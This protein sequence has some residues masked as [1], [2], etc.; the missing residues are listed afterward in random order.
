MSRKSMTARMLIALTG[1]GAMSAA[2]WAQ[3]GTLEYHGD[4]VYAQAL[5]RGRDMS[6]FVGTI[7]VDGHTHDLYECDGV[8]AGIIEAIE[9]AGYDVWLEGREIIVDTCHGSPRIRFHSH[10][11]RLSTHRSHDELHLTLRPRHPHH[12]DEVEVIEPPIVRDR[13][14]VEAP[15]IIFD[16][17]IGGGGRDRGGYGGEYRGERERNERPGH[18]DERRERDQRPGD[19]DD[20]G[21][22]GDRGERYEFEDDRFEDGRF[23]ERGPREFGGREEVRP[24]SYETQ[25]F[26]TRG[27]GDQGIT[28]D[29]DAGFVNSQ[30]PLRRR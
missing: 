22:R 14:R 12:H 11:Y 24:P 28:F 10:E 20:R 1:I 15:A 27:R 8:R 2:A 16:V 4:P 23:E 21:E 29:L 7:T 3:P 25:R 30:V 26:D 18:R 5:D 9:H 13:Y 19:R 6:S 17:S